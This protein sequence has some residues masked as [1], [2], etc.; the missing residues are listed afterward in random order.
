MRFA[1]YRKHTY[2]TIKV[3]STKFTKSSF[4]AHYTRRQWLHWLDILIEKHLILKGHGD[5]QAHNSAYI[6]FLHDFLIFYM[7]NER[8]NFWKITVFISK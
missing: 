4:V 2:R 8:M 6:E 7:S 3:H 1:Q 5:T